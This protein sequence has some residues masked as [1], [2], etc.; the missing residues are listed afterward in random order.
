MEQQIQVGAVP[1]PPSPAELYTIVVAGPMNPRLHYP[2]WYHAIGCLSEEEANAGRESGSFVMLPQAAQFDVADISISCTIERWEIR[3]TLS[4]HRDRILDIACRVFEKL[5]E[6][7]ITVFGHNTVLHLDTKAK[8]VADVLVKM[9]TDT[10]LGF[11]AAGTAQDCKI[12]FVDRKDKDSKNSTAIAVG[13]SALR[14]HAVFVSHN[15]QRAPTSDGT[16]F[17]LTPL[18]RSLRAEHDAGVAAFNE[19]V[20]AGINRA[21]EARHGN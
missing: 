20:V 9:M 21:V 2:L 4:A 11:P 12:N 18:L 10:G 16:H 6:T 19:T 1:V 17:D 7:P 13:Q 8:K 3:T 15:T 5:Y 14:D